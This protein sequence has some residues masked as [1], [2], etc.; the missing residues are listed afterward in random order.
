MTEVVIRG[1]G[2]AT[3]FPEGLEDQFPGRWN[4]RRA[5]WNDAGVLIEAIGRATESAGWWT[6]GS[7]EIV[8]GGQ[9]IG[10]DDAPIEP[11]T[12]FA[13]D[14]TRGP[15]AARATDFLFSLPSSM[16]AMAGVTFG[17]EQYQAT[18]TMRGLSG[19]RAVAHAHDLI[20][21]GRL[22]RVVVGALSV[23]DAGAFTLAV[24]WCLEAAHAER[25]T[26]TRIESCDV[27]DRAPEAAIPSAEFLPGV[28]EDHRDL[29]A[30]SM[31]AV[32]RWLESSEAGSR[33]SFVH[34]DSR[35]AGVGSMTVVTSE[36]A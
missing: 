18:V 36:D 33:Q 27:S 5:M 7:G 3:E 15:G 28:P 26:A 19:F 14:V 16:A 4:P 30:P 9:V 10:V 8:R 17:L 1:A 12:R 32:Q 23:T 24:A 11:S 31:L 22:E 2:V 21:T 25:M 6:R 35:F 20:V 34:T 13:R 29:A